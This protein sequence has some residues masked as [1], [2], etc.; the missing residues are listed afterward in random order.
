MKVIFLADLAGVANAGTIKEVKTGY[1]ENFLLK[2]GI[3]VEATTSNMKR[4]EKKLEQIKLKEQDRIKS[5]SDL[6]DKLKTIHLEFT[7]KAGE[8]GKLYGAVTAQEIA[9]A[10]NKLGIEFDKKLLDIKE[11]IKEIG[12]HELK[13]KIFKDIKTILKVTVK[14]NEEQ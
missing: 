14:A 1:A 4:L 6:A 7:R 5:A 9:D 13:I 11:A 12:T 3:A 8:T 10:I 2:K